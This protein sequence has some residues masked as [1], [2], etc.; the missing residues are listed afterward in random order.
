MN[1]S[2]SGS[3]FPVTRRSAPYSTATRCSPTDVNPPWMSRAPLCRYFAIYAP[4]HSSTKSTYTPIV[5]CVC[6]SCSGRHCCQLQCCG[7]SGLQV[8]HGDTV[9]T[10]ARVSG[11][12]PHASCKPQHASSR[13]SR[14]ETGSPISV[15]RR[16]WTYPWS[17]PAPTTHVGRVVEHDRARPS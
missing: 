15:C 13:V 16:A 5:R 7:P 17:T 12:M 14:A 3:T 4:L 11:L 10:R 2:R 1:L 8:G 6:A 9:T